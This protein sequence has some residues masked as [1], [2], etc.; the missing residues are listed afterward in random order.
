MAISLSSA[1]AAVPAPYTKV[2]ASAAEFRCLGRASALGDML[3]PKQLTAANKPMLAS[4]MRI[5]TSPASAMDKLTGN[6]KVTG[7]D[8]DSAQWQWTGESSAFRVDAHMTGDCDGF[9]WYEITL[10]PKQPIKLSSLRL[11]MP[12]TAGT[13]RYIHAAPFDWSGTARGLAE[14]GGTWKSKFMPYLWIGD[15]ERGLGWCCESDQAFRLNDPNSALR[16]ESTGNTVLTSIVLLDHEET[17]TSPITLKFGLQA[18]P[19]KPVSFAWRAKTRIFHD[20]AY[21]WCDPDKNGKIPLDTLRD[22]GVKTL[23]Y[24]DQWTDYFGRTATP[25]DKE[26]RRMIDECHKRGMKLLV[27]MGYGL[28][29]NAPE[30]QGHHD[31]W[32]VMPLIVWNPGWKP[33]FRSFDATCPRSG[34]ADWLVNGI[35]KLFTDYKLDGLYFDGTTEAWLCQNEKHGCGWRDASGN[36]HSTHAILDARRMMRRIADTVHRH[37]PS[38][39]LDAH[40]SGNLTMPTLS[41]C[42]SYY[43]GEQY[44]SYTPADKVEIPLD[45]FRAEFMGYAHGIDAEFLCYVN[46]PFTFDEAIAVAWLHGVEVRP[47]NMQGLAAVSSIWRTMDKFGATSAQWLPYWKGS[48]ATSDDSSIKAS[49][50]SKHGAALIFV[51]HLKREPIKTDLRLDRKR[52]G[53]PAGQLSAVDA[54]TRAPIQTTGD[55]LPVSFDGM[56]YRL[57]EVSPY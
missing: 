27:Y 37:N 53:L 4:P 5:V 55:A 15:E 30:M 14:I 1:F 32:S 31:D 13:A 3:L 33:E 41:F 42:D 57:I 25:H 35:D 8:G 23:I 48:G 34:W 17:I 21:D 19:V 54:I 52:L 43:D 47:L 50:F 18:T 9:C 45:A 24:H 12:R 16:V 39:I 36:L 6:G 22:A 40:M 56:S 51:S 49:V 11:E 46:R 28:A 29:R 7:N 38:A 26:L 2:K 10:T 44:E 20:V